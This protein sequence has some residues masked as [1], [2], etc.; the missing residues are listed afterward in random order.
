MVVMLL[1]MVRVVSEGLFGKGELVD[2]GDAVADGEGGEMR[3]AVEG[4]FA[5][6]GDAV[7]D[8]EGGE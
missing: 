4:V 6:G 5:D 8:G 2:G 1:P 3:V 7:A